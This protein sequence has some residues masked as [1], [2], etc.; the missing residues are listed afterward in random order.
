MFNGIP[1][2][3]ANFMGFKM[4]G[5]I[6][7]HKHTGIEVNSFYPLVGLNGMCII[8]PQRQSQRKN[9]HAMQ[10]YDAKY[11]KI[12]NV[13]MAIMWLLFNPFQ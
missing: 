2:V 7:N 4:M 1:S 6:K 5:K 9:V 8:R 12:H 3:W 10:K 13:M 11:A